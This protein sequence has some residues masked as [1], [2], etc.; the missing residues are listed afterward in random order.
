MLGRL[1][2]ELRRL[3]EDVLALGLLVGR[4]DIL[5]GRGWLGLVGR[6]L[7]LGR[8]GALRCGLDLLQGELARGLLDLGGGLCL[9]L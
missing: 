1:L 7:G 8:R 2:E 5:D 6:L 3:L 4:D 9:G